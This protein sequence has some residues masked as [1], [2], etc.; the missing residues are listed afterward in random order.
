MARLLRLATCIRER[1][2][3]AC[4]PWLPGTRTGVRGHLAPWSHVD[5][6]VMDVTRQHVGGPRAV[7]GRGAR[8]AHHRRHSV[9]FAIPSAG[10]RPRRV[11]PCLA[12]NF[13]FVS[14][15]VAGISTGGAELNA[16]IALGVVVLSV[17]HGLVVPVAVLGRRMTTGLVTL[18]NGAVHVVL[19][20]AFGRVLGLT[21]VALATVVSALVTSIP[22]G[23]A[24]L[25]AETRLRLRDVAMG[26]V[27]PSAVA[28][29]SVRRCRGNCGM[30]DDATICRRTHRKP[31]SAS[32]GLGRRHGRAALTSSE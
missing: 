26:I 29:T 11:R 20:V 25:T 30:G 1:C 10:C 27:L 15:W 4:L 17:V 9:T 7:E 8:T 23:L 3:G 32:G 31:R 14:A 12:A 5:A 28:C 22:V 18:L 21:G 2:S 16:T 13:G 6:I 24:M 19:A